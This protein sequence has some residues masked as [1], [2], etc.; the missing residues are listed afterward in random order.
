M[1]ENGRRRVDPAFRAETMV[2]E[3]AE[4]YEMLLARYADRIKNFDAKN[5]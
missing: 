3:I 1:G 2:K 5:N 4:V